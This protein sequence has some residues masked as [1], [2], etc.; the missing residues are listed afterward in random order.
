VGEGWF[1]HTLDGRK[2]LET[3]V[4]GR[5]AAG[6]A[7]AIAATTAAHAPFELPVAPA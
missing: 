5:E 3:I 7:R 4:G 1:L 2:L 6:A